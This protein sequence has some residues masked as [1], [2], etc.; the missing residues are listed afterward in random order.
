LLAAIA[1]LAGRGVPVTCLLAGRAS[2]AELM[3]MAVELGVAE[4]VRILGARQD[5]PELMRAANMVVVEGQP[6]A[7]V[8]AFAS[9]R[10][11]VATRVGVVADI[12]EDGITGLLVPPAD[13]D[14]LADAL[15]KVAGDPF[16]AAMLSANARRVAEATMRIDYRMA[17]TLAAYWTARRHARRR[18][19]PSVI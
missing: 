2:A 15:A 11:V 13:P 7:L 5:L 9:A 18:I 19:F 4:R 12:V 14:A 16:A 17:E 6:R 10:P 3:A 1:K 8:Q